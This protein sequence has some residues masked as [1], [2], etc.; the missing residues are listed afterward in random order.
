MKK[1]FTFLLL[2][3]S[4]I[5]QAQTF[6]D[7]PVQLQVRVREFNTTF[8]ATDEGALGIGFSP[9]ELS[10]KL[11]V[12]D[13]ADLDGQGWVGGN[14]LTDDF[15]PPGLSTDFN[16]TLF[17]FS[18]PGAAV[19]QFFDLRLDAWEDDNNSDALLGFCC[20]WNALRLQCA[21]VLRIAGVWYMC[22]F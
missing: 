22:G 20:K 21:P 12:R 14:C 18:Y 3:I 16:S 2:S 1:T 15:S 6:S 4:L 5:A 10:Y 9:D 13:Q 7:G 11:W 19:P 17:N 8:Q